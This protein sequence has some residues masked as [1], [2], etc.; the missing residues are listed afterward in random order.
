MAFDSILCDVV[1]M[2]CKSW[3]ENMYQEG[4]AWSNRFRFDCWPFCFRFR[5]L[6]FSVSYHWHGLPVSFYYGFQSYT[7]VPVLHVGLHGF[8]SY[9]WAYTW[10]PVLHVGLPVGSSLTRGLT[11]G[12]THGFQSY[13]RAYPWVPVLPVGLPVGP[14]NLALLQAALTRFQSCETLFM[15]HCW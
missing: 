15:W 14:S 4:R 9:T 12:L 5:T 10:V 3:E 1:T 11:R 8:R 7:W 6:L 13:P 2:K